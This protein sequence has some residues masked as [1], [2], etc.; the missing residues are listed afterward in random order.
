M[1]AP[2]TV[3]TTPVTSPTVRLETLLAN[4]AEKREEIVA[5]IIHTIKIVL[6]SKT[7]AG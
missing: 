5:E 3:S 1:A 7:I 6:F 4:C 2:N